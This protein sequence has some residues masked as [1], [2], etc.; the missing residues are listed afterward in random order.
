VTVFA[1][2]PTDNDI[3]AAA[4]Y[5]DVHYINTR[6]VYGD[7]INDQKLPH[8]VYMM[9]WRAAKE[10]DQDTDYLLLIGDHLQMV[11]FAALVQRE[12][13]EFRVLRWD[14]QAKGYVVCWVRG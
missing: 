13:G 6:Y 1:V 8:E 7:E 9:L 5:G 11:T 14:R 12:H 10:F 2:N 3:S 4:E